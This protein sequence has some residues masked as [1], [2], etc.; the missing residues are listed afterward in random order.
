MNRVFVTGLG[1]ITSIGQTV[2][3]NWRNLLAGQCG[4]A[5]AVRFSGERFQ[6]APVCTA[7]FPA[8]P[9]DDPFLD[10]ASRILFAAVTEALAG[11]TDL[12][13]APIYL[14]STMGGMEQGCRFYRDYQAHGLTHQNKKL[15]S[16]Y[17]PYMQGKHLG[18]RFGFHRTPV[19]ICNAC[20]SGANALGLAHLALQSG[21]APRALVAGFDIVSEFV[22]GGFNVLRLVSRTGCRPFDR[23]REGLVLGEG[24][25]ALIL[26][27]RDS[28]QQSDRTPIAELCAYAAT[29]DTYH[30]TQPHPDGHGAEKVMQDCLRAAGWKPEE[31][32][33]LNAHGTGTTHN[34][35]MEARAARRVF[36][37][38][39]HMRIT[40][41]KGAIGH[42][43]GAAG[44]IEAVF[45]I[46][47]LRD[48]RIPPVLGLRQPL[49]ELGPIQLPTQ[50]E[51]RPLRRV[52]ST[53]YGFGGTNACLAFSTGET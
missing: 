23:D 4:A 31:V 39:P 10:N 6:G 28:I 17:V 27:T 13:D 12:A 8:P 14:A 46:L 44:A 51:T 43:L 53:S 47:M 9:R 24:A 30:V 38:H 19:V 40:A 11:R 1:L 45:S 21:A 32:D 49:E 42:T 36:A 15:L 50:V 37:G 20:S 5:E 3:E 33:C 16:D 2:E 48:G 7:R 34:D 52:L 26:E 22:F 25:A 29:C 18:E 41:N 35:L